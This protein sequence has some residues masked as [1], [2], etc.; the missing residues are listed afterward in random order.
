LEYFKR[1]VNEHP[2]CE[3]NLVLAG[4]DAMAVQRADRVIKLGFIPQELKASIIANALLMVAPSPYES[5]CISALES[6]MQGVPVLANG[7][8]LVL[9]GQC[10]RSGAGL[11]YRNYAEFA[12][13]LLVLMS[14]RKLRLALGNSGRT[15]VR[16]EFSWAEVEQRYV[17]AI[18]AVTE[19]QRDLDDM[20]GPICGEDDLNLIAG[21]AL[22]RK[23]Q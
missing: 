22:A 19:P 3:L 5:L 20:T 1:F 2:A 16:C 15:F 23:I 17:R 13:C 21:A 10:R 4:R 18:A 9:A 11:W 8:C 6:W 14:D 12:E 7:E